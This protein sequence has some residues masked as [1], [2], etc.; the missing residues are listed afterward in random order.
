MVQRP[1]DLKQE[2]YSR[3][4]W[5]I[6]DNFLRIVFLVTLVLVGW[7]FRTTMELGNRITSIESNRLSGTEILDNFKALQE[8]WAKDLIIIRESI[9]MLPKEIPPPWFAQRVDRLEGRLDSVVER[10]A[11]IEHRLSSIQE[12][13]Q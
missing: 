13:V 12:K 5:S 11:G 6:V 8:C 4:A 1:T 9:A 3:F 7:N 10:L 2:G